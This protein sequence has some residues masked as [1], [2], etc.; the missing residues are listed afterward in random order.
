MVGGKQQA[1]VADGRTINIAP[2]KVGIF[3]AVGSVLESFNSSCGM[4][5][6]KIALKN[7]TNIIATNFYWE[8]VIRKTIH[9]KAV[10]NKT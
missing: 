6:P 3:H 1:Q 5:A 4:L 8:Q 10:E 9:F 7:E 2:V